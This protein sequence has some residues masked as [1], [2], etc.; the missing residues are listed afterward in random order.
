MTKLLFSGVEE[1]LKT[2]LSPVPGR[3]AAV[4]GENRN[5]WV[6]LAELVVIHTSSQ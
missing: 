1:V 4:T 2:V 5:E 3:S 6:P